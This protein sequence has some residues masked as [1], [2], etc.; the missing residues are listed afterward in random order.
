VCGGPDNVGS[1]V[2]LAH[3]AYRPET[4]GTCVRTSEAPIG[5]ASSSVMTTWAQGAVRL[6]GTR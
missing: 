2:G 6:R 3:H 1:T 4:A 5:S